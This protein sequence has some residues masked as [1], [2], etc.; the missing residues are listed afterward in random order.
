MSFMWPWF[1]RHTGF[2]SVGSERTSP[3]FQKKALVAE[4]CALERQLY[5]TMI[6][7]LNVWWRF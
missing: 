3:R 5:E 6:V 2:K 7:K 1:Y 4:H